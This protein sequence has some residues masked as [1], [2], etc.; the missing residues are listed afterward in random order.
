MNETNNL[1]Y[2]TEEINTLKTSLKLK[3]NKIQERIEPL[4]ICRNHTLILGS[5]E[6]IRIVMKIEKIKISNKKDLYEFINYYVNNLESI[7]SCLNNLSTVDLTLFED[8]F[9]QFQDYVSRE[10]GIIPRVDDVN[11]DYAN[12]Y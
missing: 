9:N 7:S 4:E 6:Y 3:I 5:L 2:S 10:L 11:F 1:V 12:Y 8:L